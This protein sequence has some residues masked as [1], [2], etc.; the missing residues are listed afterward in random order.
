MAKTPGGKVGRAIE[1]KARAEMG[2]RKGETTGM[3]K[4][5][6]LSFNGPVPAQQGNSQKLS[7]S[8]RDLKKA[9]EIAKNVE[10]RTSPSLSQDG[11][12]GGAHAGGHG[13]SEEEMFAGK[14][15][16]KLGGLGAL[17]SRIARATEGEVPLP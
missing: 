10:T 13:I 9:I 12:L 6:R 7:G 14:G 4:A 15:P 5:S 17:G 2:I 8:I 3:L 16:A 11:R 1:N